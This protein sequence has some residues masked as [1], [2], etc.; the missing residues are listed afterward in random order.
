MRKAAQISLGA[1]AILMLANLLVLDYFWW[2]GRSNPPLAQNKAATG[3]EAGDTC[4]SLCQKTITEKI[5][6]ELD[7]NT[8]SAGQSSS[9]TVS[10]PATCAVLPT[11]GPQAKILYIPLASQGSTVETI[12]TDIPGSDFY[13]DL[14]DYLAVKAVRFEI[15]LLALHGSAKVYARLYDVTNKR[16]VDFSELSTQSSTF[17]RLDSGELRIWRGDNRYTVQLRSENGTEVQLKEAKLKIIF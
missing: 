15:R 6:A 3:Q 1:L 10:P 17:L 5:Q 7:K 9:V 4:G 16:A 2:Q 12:W 8:P 11:A 13:F 14:A